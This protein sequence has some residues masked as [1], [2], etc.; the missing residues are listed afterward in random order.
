[1]RTFEQSETL[2]RLP[3]QFFAKLVKNVQQ[4]Q[5]AGHDVINLGQG[6]PDLPTPEHIVKALQGASEDPINHKYSPFQGFLYAKQAMADFYQREYGVE[7]DPETE[8]A[9][10]F[11][12]K[13]GLA[14]VSQCL[15]NPGDTALVPD[16]G[17]PDYMSGIALADAKTEMMPLLAANDF[18]PD[19]QQIPEDVLDLAKIMFLNYPNNPTSA[20]ATKEF[21]D[22]TVKVAKEHQFCVL[23]DFAYGSIGF[24]GNKPQSFLQS[25]GAKDVGIEMYTLS[26]TYNMA[27]W[28]VAFAVGNKS[29][30]KGIN[31]LQ[32][33]LH[34]SLFGGIQA[35]A[36]SALNGDQEVVRKLVDTYENRRNCFIENL[37]KIGW[38][39]EAP[40]GTFFA[41]LPVPDGYSSEEF[42]ELLLNKAHVATAPGNGFGSAGEGYVRVGLLADEER[43][44]EAAERIGNL[45]IFDR[46][47]EGMK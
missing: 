3:E 32:D 45:N 31:L 41:W 44:A 18:L 15:L 36:A 14:E 47:S 38:K 22:E 46:K 33:H 17:Y 10:M 25:E 35:A 16:P 39:V 9:I 13:E 19:Y 7:L 11:G 30:V 2:K 26:K 8:V 42:S 27:G 12:S 5:S 34:V 40:K 1:M 21:F 43:L 24:D 28:R 20:T 29:V 6:N 4:L 37:N 23:H